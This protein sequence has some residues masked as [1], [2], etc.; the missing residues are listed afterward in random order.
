MPNVCSVKN[1]YHDPSF[2]R[3]GALSHGIKWLLKGEKSEKSATLRQVDD[4]IDYN[5]GE[6]SEKAQASYNGS[7]V[8]RSLNYLDLFLFGP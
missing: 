1:F 4:A 3:Q 6:R 5:H 7:I 8:Q 2:F